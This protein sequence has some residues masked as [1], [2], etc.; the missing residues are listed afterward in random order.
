[1]ALKIQSTIK[2]DGGFPVAEAG[3]I[4]MPDG[5][6]LSEFEGGAG[7]YIGNTES[8]TPK[9]I[10]SE[11]TKNKTVRVS[12]ADD[13]YGI[14]IFGNFS[15]AIN[16]LLVASSIVLEINNET[17]SASLVGDLSTDKWI[18]SAEEIA[19][20]EDLENV[21]VKEPVEVDITG[22]NENGIITEEYEDGSTNTYTFVYD[23]ETDSTTITD[24][25][26]LLTVVKGL[27]PEGG[28]GGEG[29]FSPIVT[30]TNITGGHRVSIT[31]IEGTKT[32]DV[33]DGADGKNGTN[34]TNG[35]DGINGKDGTNGKDGAD[36]EDGF[37]P[38]VAVSN[39]TG[40][41]RVSITDKDG[42]K[43]FD[44]MDGKD[45][46]GGG[47]AV[48]E[49][50]SGTTSEITPADVANAIAEGRPI[51]L[52]YTDSMYGVVAFTNFS[53]GI[54]LGAVVSS[55]T[56]EYEGTTLCAY[57]AGDISYSFWQ[58]EVI[59]L[60]KA[61][62]SGGAGLPEVSTADNGKF[63]RVVNGAWAAEIVPSAEEASF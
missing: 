2:P 44:V 54:S 57:L 30:V 38:T 3:D 58:F 50:L 45:G 48:V 24:S 20:K 31:D 29:G 16:A 11:I 34:G 15:Y 25:K 9:K 10:A 13:N 22:F 23:E 36:G 19:K 43:T 17:V 21:T 51:Y 62:E 41:H 28:S 49:P 61:G 55:F 26:G 33:M 39:I 32:F 60:A 63:L 7:F 8:D 27:N 18:F 53:A 40:G 46:E 35:K 5:K 37:S 59:E 4:L 14:I 52:T 12:H 6:R 56:F 42:T 47:S 1:M